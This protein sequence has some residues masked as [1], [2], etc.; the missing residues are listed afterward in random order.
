[1]VVMFGGFG[2]FVCIVL[3]WRRE[4]V[5]EE[6]PSGKRRGLA[7]AGLLGVVN[8][9]TL[10]VL[11]AWLL[12]GLCEESWPCALGASGAIVSLALGLGIVPLLVWFRRN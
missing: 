5:P 3:R 6:V 4:G 8:A 12:N 10:L 9:M 2:V 1:M 11:G 7:L